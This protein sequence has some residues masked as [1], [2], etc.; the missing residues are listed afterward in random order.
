M[1]VKKE[2]LVR[3]IEHGT[4]IDHINAGQAL[5]VI[6]I[7]GIAGSTGSVVS[8]AM[9]VASKQMELKDI[10]KIEGRELSSKQV[11]KISLISPDATINIIR[12]YDVISKYNVELPEEI[13]GIVRCNNPDCI[14]N[15][16]EPV[17]SSFTVTKKPVILRCKYCD[18]IISE[19][20]AEQLI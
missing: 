8:I 9:N 2:L 3:P 19:E 18:H 20:I 5:N 12:N 7:I 10:V 15:S 4:V 14:T 6:R 17:A 13:T 1:C 11:D 16:D